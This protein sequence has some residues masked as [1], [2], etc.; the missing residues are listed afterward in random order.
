LQ[1]GHAEFSDNALAAS[2]LR[3]DTKVNLDIFECRTVFHS[4]FDFFVRYALANADDHFDGSSG[5]LEPVEDVAQRADRSSGRVV[6]LANHLP[7]V[8]SR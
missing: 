4:L 1:I 7:Q 2:A 5:Q 8:G 3:S 6:V